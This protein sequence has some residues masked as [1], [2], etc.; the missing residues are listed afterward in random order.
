MAADDRV[1]IA[2][3][4][5]VGCV[6]AL[7]LARAGIPVTLFEAEDSLP[8]DLRASTFHPPTLDMLEHLGVVRGVVPQLERGTR[9]GWQRV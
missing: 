2:G 3:A 4:G 7:Y 9:T 5:P 8:L 1:L 6:A